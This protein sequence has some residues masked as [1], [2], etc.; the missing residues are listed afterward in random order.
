MRLVSVRQEAH[1]RGYRIEGVKQGEG[2]LLRVPPTRRVTPTRPDLPTLSYSQF[3][4]LRSTW[5][6][7]VDV[8]VGYI[9]ESLDGTSPSISA[10]PAFRPAPDRREPR[11]PSP[12]WSELK[13]LQ[14]QL[15]PEV[16]PKPTVLH[17]VDRT[18]ST[19]PVPHI[20]KRH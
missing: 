6:N 10:K 7:A 8:V 16:Q 11:G 2:I 19:M 12:V 9:D 5:R 20:S 4:T 18:D 13:S 15:R 14:A 3:R 17:L 1:H